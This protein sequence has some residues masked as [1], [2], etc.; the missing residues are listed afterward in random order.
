VYISTAFSI[1]VS[2][3]MVGAGAGL[4]VSFFWGCMPDE[5]KEYLRIRLDQMRG[6]K[7]E[8]ED[9]EGKITEGG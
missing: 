5:L 7:A 6:D 9:D 3:M 4:A 2:L 1:A 8:D